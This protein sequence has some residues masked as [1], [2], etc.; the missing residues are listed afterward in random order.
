MKIHAP[1]FLNIPS[2][3]L[4]KFVSSYEDEN[5]FIENMAIRGATTA[6]Y[7]LNGLDHIL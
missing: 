4:K 1:T 2:K 5:R 3:E 6:N 7:I